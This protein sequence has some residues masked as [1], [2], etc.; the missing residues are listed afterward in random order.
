LRFPGIINPIEI[1]TAG[2]PEV[3][4]GKTQA[5]RKKPPSASP[6]QFANLPQPGTLLFGYPWILQVEVRI[7]QSEDVWPIRASR[8]QQTPNPRI[9]PPLASGR[10]LAYA[11]SID[12]PKGSGAVE[13]R[14][15]V[16]G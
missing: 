6:P 12:S 5:R 14:R 1:I 4:T 7:R 11:H 15:L 16:T 3:S 8:W 13:R 9:R 10:A 2:N